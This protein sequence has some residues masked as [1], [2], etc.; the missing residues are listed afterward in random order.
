MAGF[1]FYFRRGWR[2]RAGEILIAAGAEGE[3]CF[4]CLQRELQAAILISGLT[5][6]TANIEKNQRTKASGGYRLQVVLWRNKVRAFP[7]RLFS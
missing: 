4:L 5:S 7:Q 3:F 6:R 2:E 1:E